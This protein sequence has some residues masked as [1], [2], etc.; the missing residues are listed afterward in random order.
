[1][2]KKICRWIMVIGIIIPMLGSE[3]IYAQAPEVQAKSALLVDAKSGQIL[4]D[5]AGNEPR[6]IA[7]TTKML[8]QYIVLSNIKK[9]E[10]NWTD[11]VTISD[12]V[13]TLTEDNTLANLPLDQNNKFTVRELFMGMSIASANAMTVVLAEHIA[14]SEEAFV[15]EMQALVES[16]GIKDAYLVNSTGLNN[17]YLPADYGIRGGEDVEN[18][19]SA[20]SL[21]IVARHLVTDFPEILETSSI[22]QYTYRENTP[23]ELTVTN[24]NVMLPG[25]FY[26]YPG[27]K[28]LKTGTTERAGGNFVGYLEQGDESFISVV[29]HSGDGFIDKYS[30]F[31]VTK[32]LFDYGLYNLSPVT[33]KGNSLV[34]DELNDYPVRNGTIETVDLRVQG[35]RSLYLPDLEAESY[36]IDYHINS[37]WLDDQGRLYHTFEAN[38]IVGTATIHPLSET[39]DYL[40]GESDDRLTLPIVTTQSSKKASL[41]HRIGK[42]ISDFWHRLQ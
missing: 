42:V 33:I 38:Q 7:S 25:L 30:R 24:Y 1:M 18:Q 37:E 40:Q 22:P 23:M 12:S 11:Q 13:M 28:G 21:A 20:K 34:S 16:W 31:Q 14:G 5:Q 10:L 2:V 19:M 36:D 15:K 27:V 41:V 17:K 6:E 26:A 32:F 29:L 9:G 3:I 8:V 4:V 35:D 39:D